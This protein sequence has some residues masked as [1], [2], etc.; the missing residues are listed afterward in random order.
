MVTT[1]DRWATGDGIYR[2]TNGGTAWTE[3]GAT[4]VRDDSG[5]KWLYWHRTTPSA[6]GW[7]G[8]IDI[9]PFNSDHVL[10][11]TGQGVW[12]TSDASRAD[13]S[14][15]TNWSFR[16]RGLE[17]TAVLDLASP[18]S[19]A[20][21]LS[22]LGDIAGFKHDDLA[23]S[24][25]RGMFDNPIF[26]NTTS[27]DFAE[28]NPMLVVRVG[29][30]GSASERRGAYSTDGGNAWTPFGSEPAGS[31][32]QGAVAISADGTTLVWA[33]KDSA[34][35]FSRDRGA[36]W[37]PISGLPNNLKPVSD[38]VNS[39]R[40]YAFDGLNGRLYA[41]S[42]RGATFAARASGLPIL[43]DYALGDG[44]VQPVPGVDGDLWL[45]AGT[46]GLRHSTDGGMTFT[47]VSGVSEANAFG[48]GKAAQGSA[49]P[50][51]F[52]IGKVGDAVGFFRS[53]DSGASWKRINDDQHQFGWAS[54]I[55]GDPR[56][57]GRVY[58]G[59]NGRGILY[60]E[61]AR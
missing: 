58:V 23:A 35:A 47:A 53:D 30:T 43:P 55:T 4:G 14:Q 29:T 41:S 19:G 38:R 11:V 1:I 49:Y 54:L 36:G 12:G 16:S 9:D 2:T 7:M 50:A 17:E 26:G 22:A 25:A 31:N 60:G 3:L 20:P 51:L 46:G 24:P 44:G 37:T 40:F 18:P 15:P 8:D 21:L 45:Y 27:L 34:P 33:P 48:F 10:Y 57:F 42:D 5:A 13:S 32:G 56:V 39:S 61:P 59:T 52:L 28:S 6:T